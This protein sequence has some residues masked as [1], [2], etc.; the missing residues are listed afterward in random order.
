MEFFLTLYIKY[1]NILSNYSDKKVFA[2][3]PLSHFIEHVVSTCE[4]SITTLHA[5]RSPPGRRATK[6]M[7]ES[8]MP[9]HIYLV[10]SAAD[11]LCCM[12]SLC[13]P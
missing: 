12:Q 1:S 10:C 9:A 5:V 3:S 4:R 2:L 6:A 7:Q 13:M 8:K 11:K